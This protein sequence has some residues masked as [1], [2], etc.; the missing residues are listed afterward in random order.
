MLSL[1]YTID[2]EAQNITIH[3]C[4]NY[5]QM[6]VDVDDAIVRHWHYIRV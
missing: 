5:Y 1:V 3:I 2:A 4:S 6:R